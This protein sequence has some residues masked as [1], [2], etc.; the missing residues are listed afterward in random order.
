MGYPNDL[1]FIY[2]IT[3]LKVRSICVDTQSCNPTCEV[4][5]IAHVP[6]GVS[7]FWLHIYQNKDLPTGLCTL[8]VWAIV[9]SSINDNI[10]SS[11]LCQAAL[12]CL[13]QPKDE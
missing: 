3:R 4:Y 7:L 5:V 11:W 6:A 13:N 2:R 9:L 12:P 10:R 8:L 1:C